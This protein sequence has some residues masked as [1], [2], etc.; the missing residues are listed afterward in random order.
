MKNLT[1]LSK[2]LL[3]ALLVFLFEATYVMAQTNE[4]HP[5]PMDTSQHSMTV[6][7]QD[8]KWEKIF[9]DFGDESPEIAILRVDPQTQ[10]THLLIRSPKAFYVPRHW[11]SANETHTVL[12][13]TFI[14]EC[15]GKRDTLGPGS[16]NYIPS[17]MIHQAWTPAQ[18]LL[19][20]T[21]DSAWDINWVDGPPQ[22][23]QKSKDLE[24]KKK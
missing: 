23:P 22:P 20:I 1:G 17:K 9:P 13:G 2:G 16:F 3:L 11:H 4:K 21:V 15:E 14:F 5:M 6:K 8:V 7:F 19:F 18:G 10:A 12:S 24:Q